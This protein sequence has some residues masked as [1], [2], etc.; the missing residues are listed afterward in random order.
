MKESRRKVMVRDVWG[1]VAL[2]ASVPARDTRCFRHCVQEYVFQAFLT[3]IWRCAQVLVAC[4]E[5]RSRERG[6][7][8]PD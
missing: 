4:I 1:L 8:A 3:A 7:G 2:D 6:R 5:I